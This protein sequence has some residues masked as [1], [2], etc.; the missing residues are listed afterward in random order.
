MTTVMK[1]SR[2]L[3]GLLLAAFLAVGTAA[4]GAAV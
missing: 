3:I 2:L 1:K 4:L